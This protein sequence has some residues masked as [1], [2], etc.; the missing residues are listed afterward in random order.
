LVTGG[1]R[2]IGRAIA[3]R[4]AAAECRVA[5]LSRTAAELDA[6]V[7]AA[8]AVGSEAVMPIVAD[9]TRDTDLERAVQTI[10]ERLGRIAILVNNAGFAT[11]RRPIVQSALDDWDRTLD[12][13][14]RAP[15]VLTRLVLP[16][17]LAHASGTIINIA[18][19]AAKHGRSGEAAYAAAKFGLL[20]FTQSLYDE[21]HNRGIKV[22]A[23][24]PG[25]VDTTLIPPNARVD[26]AKFLQPEDIADLVYQVVI[27]PFR[28]CPRE[29]IVEP[30]YDPAAQ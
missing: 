1:G 29:I 15:M 10:L 12:T 19:V 26:R 25:V 27:S 11:P 24:C 23:I 14:L 16:D 3:L 17:M 7:E 4:L 20:G 6:T 22:T 13:C 28:M 8:A 5:V 9:V 21:V 30:Q 2:G 18:S